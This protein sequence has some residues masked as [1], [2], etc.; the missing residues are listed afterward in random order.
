MQGPLYK[1]DFPCYLSSSASP[2][3]GYGS[4]NCQDDALP[5]ALL[6]AFFAATRVHAQ[7]TFTTLGPVFDLPL[8]VTSTVFD[9]SMISIS[10]V[11]CSASVFLGSTFRAIV[12]TLVG[13]P[14]VANYLA[15]C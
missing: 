5:P 9:T 12:N 10:T 8:D 2:S 13:K 15:R 7:A 6:S 1:S 11:D 3:L 14:L 4:S